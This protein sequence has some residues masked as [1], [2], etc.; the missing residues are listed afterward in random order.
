MNGIG[1]DLSAEMNN[2]QHRPAF[3][4]ITAHLRVGKFAMNDSEEKVRKLIAQ[5]YD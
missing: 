1:K 2:P 3:D 4:Y 5:I